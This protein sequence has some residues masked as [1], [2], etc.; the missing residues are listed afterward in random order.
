MKICKFLSQSKV[1]VRVYVAMQRFK[2]FTL[3]SMSPR[4]TMTTLIEDKTELLLL[5]WSWT[6]AENPPLSWAQRV[7]IALDAARGLE[8]I[9]EHIKPT[10]IHRDIKTANILIDGNV[11]AKVGPTPLTPCIIISVIQTRL[12]QFTLQKQKHSSN[13]K[14]RRKLCLVLCRWQTSVW[15]S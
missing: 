11:R 1:L 7:E 4:S 9:H 5:L 14:S 13:P 15:Q 3:S 8:Y 12:R 10:Y 6:L 2:M